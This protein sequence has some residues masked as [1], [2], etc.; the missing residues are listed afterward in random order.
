MQ[1]TNTPIENCLISKIYFIKVDFLI[2]KMKMNQHA[3]ELSAE[4]S[5]ISEKA[6]GIRTPS[7]ES[8]PRLQIPQEGFV[9]NCLF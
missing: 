2:V 8:R 7:V 6:E 5:D 1:E 9:L 4:R 3:L